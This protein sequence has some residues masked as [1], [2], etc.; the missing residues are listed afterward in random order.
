MS[1]I[2]SV[3]YM[4]QLKVKKEYLLELHFSTGNDRRI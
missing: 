4:Y 3:T 2:K 1:V